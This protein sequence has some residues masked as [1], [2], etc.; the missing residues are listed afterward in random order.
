MHKAYLMKIE[1][2]CSQAIPEVVFIE[3][4]KTVLHHFPNQSGHS[5]DPPIDR[6]FCMSSLL[7]L[8]SQSLLLFL[9][10]DFSR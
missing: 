3:A 1:N 9:V 7:I 8:F 6:I 2:L 10:S 4:H 5:R